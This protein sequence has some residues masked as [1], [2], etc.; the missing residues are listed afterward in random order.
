MMITYDEGGTCDFVQ[1]VVY[2]DRR[3]LATADIREGLKR[4]AKIAIS[5]GYNS[6]FCDPTELKAYT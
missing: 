5:C 3:A 4:Q 2:V 1:G 6:P